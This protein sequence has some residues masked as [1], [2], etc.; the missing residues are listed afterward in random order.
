MDMALLSTPGAGYLRKRNIFVFTLGMIFP[1]QN[2]E[3]WFPT[4]ASG[5]IA[6]C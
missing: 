2:A 3:V 6:G 1:R 5:A 4:V